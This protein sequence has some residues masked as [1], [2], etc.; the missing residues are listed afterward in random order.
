VEGIDG[1]GFGLE[2]EDG[3]GFAIGCS[4]LGPKSPGFSGGG[5]TITSG[6]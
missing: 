1:I 4:G 3:G 5:V 2:I 6:G